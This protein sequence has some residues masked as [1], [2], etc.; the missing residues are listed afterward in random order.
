M[1]LVP[2]NG[3]NTC[4]SGCSHP[5]AIC[6]HLWHFGILDRACSDGL[7][8]EALILQAR[9]PGQSPDRDALVGASSKILAIYA[10][11]QTF[12]CL[13]W[14]IDGSDKLKAR[15]YPTLRMGSVAE[16]L[17]FAC[18]DC[19]PENATSSTRHSCKSVVDKYRHIVMLTI[20]FIH[21]QSKSTY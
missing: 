11:T 13:S 4:R 7:V 15:S 10:P 17:G 21:H 12:P 18:L 9:C 5:R 8:G 19:S 16:Q 6:S 2:N 20:D 3:R 1:F 14:A